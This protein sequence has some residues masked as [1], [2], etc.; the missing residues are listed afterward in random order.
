[1]AANIYNPQDYQTI[2]RRIEALSESK[3]R[4]WGT[5]TI[6]QML[7][8]CSR[9]LQSGLGELEYTQLE[10]SP[11][12]RTGLV[13]WLALYAMPWSKGLPTASKM[14]MKKQGIVADDFQ[15]ERE[16]LLSLL[17]RIQEEPNLQPHPL[18]GTLGQKDWG[19]LIWKHLDHHL[20]QFGG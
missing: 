6:G 15:A 1:M 17:A 14:N 13:R 11:L 3:Q 16:N 4:K 20:K 12:L 9:Q 2:I 8:H 7:Q 5:M 19:R 18:F 10:G